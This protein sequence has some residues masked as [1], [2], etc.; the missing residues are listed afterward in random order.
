MN[1][2]LSD[3][4]KI[5]RVSNAVSA[6]TSAVNCTAVNMAGYDS[7]CFVLNVGALTATQVTALKAAQS[8]DNGSSD[9]WTDIEGS[10]VGPF[11][12]SDGN[13]QLILDIKKP[14]KQYVRATVNRATANAVIDTVIAILY[15]ARDLPVTQDATV[16][17][18][19]K[20]VTPAEGTA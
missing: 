7:V 15:N 11:G 3:N 20:L 6:G 2:H 18:H 13:D 1:T 9:D 17:D 14:G 12:D 10:L 16:I 8:S 4:V 19:H 5:V